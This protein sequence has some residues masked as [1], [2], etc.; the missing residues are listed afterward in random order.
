M[1]VHFLQEKSYI[2]MFD[3]INESKT[4]LQNRPNSFLKDFVQIGRMLISIDVFQSGKKFIRKDL[5]S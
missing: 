5:S 2:C 1:R 3:L 4:R